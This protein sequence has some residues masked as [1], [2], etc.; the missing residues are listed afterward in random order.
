MNKTEIAKKATSLIV[1]LGTTKIVNDVVANN[2]TAEKLHE[3][4][5][6]KA[7]ALVMGAMVADKTQEYTDRRIDEIVAWWTANVTNRI[8]TKN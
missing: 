7:G 1:G 4:V 2:T 8:P 6:I 3:K 5:E